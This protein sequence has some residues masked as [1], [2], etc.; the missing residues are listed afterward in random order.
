MTGLFEGIV[1]A[2]VSFALNLCIIA[3]IRRNTL[4][5]EGGQLARIYLATL[6]L[7][8]ILAI[9]LN[10]YAADVGF[11]ATF[12]GDSSTYDWGGWLLALKWA[13][14][15]YATP[16]GAMGVSGYGFSY[17]VALLYYVFGHNQLLVQFVNA[18]LGS[19]AVV[20]I[21]AIA[22][23][24]F[25]TAVARWSALFMA[26]FPQMVFWSCAIYKDPAVL[27]CIAL[28]IY[29]VLRLRDR[30]SMLQLTFFVAAALALMSLRFY[31]FYMVVVATAGTFAFSY[32][33]GFLGGAASQVMLVLALVIAIVFGVRSETLRQQRDYFDLE[34]LQVARADQANLG[35]SAFGAQVDVSTPQGALAAIPIG[36]VYLLLAPF[37]WAVSGVRQI[38]SFPEMVVWYALL[39]SLVRGLSYAL[40]TRFR[41]ALPVLAFALLLTVAYAVFQSNV[42][43]VYRQRTQISMFFFIFMGAGIEAKK[44]TRLARQGFHNRVVG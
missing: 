3:A 18:T 10:Q 23:R 36:L 6:V 13:G 25:D 44:R 29:S 24:L 1:A 12:W 5:R 37:P 27:L 39:P 9:V 30:F 2:I 28:C 11:A 34:R 4:G 42:G 41:A 38:L 7:R 21:Y 20:V 14:E 33:R 22:K 16:A 17:F 40:K 15:T 32:R 19:V 26:F 8:H 31:V 43:T 35:H